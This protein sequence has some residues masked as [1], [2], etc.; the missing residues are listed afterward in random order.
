MERG[1]MRKKHK[2]NI[3]IYRKVTYRKKI[4]MEKE[5]IQKIDIY[6]VKTQIK[7]RYIQNKNIYKKRYVQ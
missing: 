5:Q 4:Y 3:D 6:R 7:R 2:Q 1:Q